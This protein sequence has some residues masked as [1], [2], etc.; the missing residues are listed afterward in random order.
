MIVVPKPLRIAGLFLANLFA[1]VVG[2]AVIEAGISFGISNPKTIGLLVA[3]DLIVAFALGYFSYF[4]LKSATAKWVW[5]A[6]LC[7]FGQRAIGLWLDQGTVRRLTGNH[8]MAPSGLL[9]PTADAQSFSN[10]IT[11]TIP[12]I[13]TVFYSAGAF[14]CSIFTNPPLLDADP[15]LSDHNSNAHPAPSSDVRELIRPD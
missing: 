14:C 9:W 8:D 13:R 6:G 11:Y 5:V 2:T 15:A 10:W 4:K 12:F 7:W 3:K 1:A